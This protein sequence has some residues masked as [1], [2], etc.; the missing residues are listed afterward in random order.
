MRD[1]RTHSN[2]P[3]CAPFK[4][5]TARMEEPRILLTSLPRH[6]PETALVHRYS[7]TGLTINLNHAIT[8]QPRTWPARV[9]SHEP[10]WHPPATH[11]RLAAWDQFLNRTAPFYH[12]LKIPPLPQ[13]N[14]SLRHRW[15]PAPPVRT[16]GSKIPSVAARPNPRN[17]SHASPRAPPGRMR[18]LAPWRP[19]PI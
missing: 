1:S 10:S 15:L 8:C 5:D 14:P 4:T 17:P 2:S 3:K 19:G 12:L 13:K 9:S 11:S 16:T 7:T 18:D 6:S